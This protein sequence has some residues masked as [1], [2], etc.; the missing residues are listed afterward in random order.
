M[1]H[2]IILIDSGITNFN[3]NINL[4]SG[5]SLEYKKNKII[6][7]KNTKDKTGHGT[8]CA[9]CISLN[10]SNPIYPI[11]IFDNNNNSQSELLLEALNLARELPY[12]IINLSLSV[13]NP[14]Y[15][16]DFNNAIASLISNKK[17]IVCSEN[18]EY[19]NSYPAIHPEIFGVRGSVL[20]NNH[21]FWYRSNSKLQI[22]TDSTPI[23]TN[24]FCKHSFFGGN[25]KA[26]AIFSGIL[27]NLLTTHCQT[28]L[29]EILMSNTSNVNW[30]DNDL[31][32]KKKYLLSSRYLNVDLSLLSTLNEF[33]SRYYEKNNLSL[34][35]NIKDLDLISSL[36]LPFECILEFKQALEQNYNV[37]I[38]NSDVDFFTFYNKL[39]VLQLLS[40][41]SR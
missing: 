32:D 39:E 27:S 25:S 12:N 30:N 37:R 3:K 2:G 5:V 16:T 17:V 13:S 21:K 7:T 26:A 19:Q 4:M 20:R 24:H 23:F 1:E 31:I 18:N 36:N 14:N 10:T 34:F 28:S 15:F 6:T 22:S 33:I 40:R 11:K 35:S 9:Y 41:L 8:C 38:P 29:H